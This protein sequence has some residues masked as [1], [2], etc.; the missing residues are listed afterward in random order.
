MTGI[1]LFTAAVLAIG[2]PGAF[3]SASDH[4]AMTTARTQEG[5]ILASW[6]VAASDRRP[7]DLTRRSRRIH[8]T[9]VVP[10]CGELRP[11]FILRRVAVERTRRAVVLT[12]IVHN[13]D[14]LPPGSPCPGNA[15]AKT[16]AVG[17]RGP[18]GQRELR[19]GYYAPPKLVGTDPRCARRPSDRPECS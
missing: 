9:Y 6:Q 16:I 7:G 13:P 15:V 2:M 14:A 8:I 12:V 17:L 10:A 18:L 3:D 5:G 1:P 19:D 11:D 4:R